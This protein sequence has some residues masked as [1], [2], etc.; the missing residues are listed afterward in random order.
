VE[1]VARDV[2][3]GFISR[4]S[5]MNDYGVVIEDDGRARRV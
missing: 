1:L 3:R 5:A 4:E 2:I